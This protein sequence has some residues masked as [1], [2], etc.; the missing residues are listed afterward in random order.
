MN[1]DKNKLHHTQKINKEKV[2][3]VGGERDPEPRTVQ[4]YACKHRFEWTPGTPWIC[5]KCH[6]YMT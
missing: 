5:P 3:I 2:D 6:S 4:C 1:R